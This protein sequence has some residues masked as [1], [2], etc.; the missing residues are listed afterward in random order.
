MVLFEQAELIVLSMYIILC[1]VQLIMNVVVPWLSTILRS[2]LQNG[3]EIIVL[4][5]TFNKCSTF[6]YP[7]PPPPKKKKK[8]KERKKQ[9]C[10]TFL[11]MI[12]VVLSVDFF[13]HV[14]KCSVMTHT[15]RFEM[16]VYHN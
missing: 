1:S 14:L 8:K 12:E 9:Q 13:F 5:R 6:H 7:L 2:F 11:D 15:C 4:C 16:M 10:F 3:L